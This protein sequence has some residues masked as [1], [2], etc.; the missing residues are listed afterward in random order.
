MPGRRVWQSMSD[1]AFRSH[2][3]NQK[4]EVDNKLVPLGKAWLE[5]PDRPSA[6]G[7]TFDT[8]VSPADN[9]NARIKNGRLNLWT[10]FGVVPVQKA[11]GWKI[12]EAMIRDDLCAGN[13]SHFHY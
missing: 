1:Q 4:L 10:G 13:E 5:S 11:D 9:I 8:S 2:F 3:S 12:F 6:I 7:L